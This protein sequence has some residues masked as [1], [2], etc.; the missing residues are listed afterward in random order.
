MTV[1][2]RWFAPLTVGMTNEYD[3]RGRLESILTPGA[4]GRS[5]RAPLRRRQAFALG[6]G[7][8]TVLLLLSLVN[9]GGTAYDRTWGPNS[10]FRTTRAFSASGAADSGEFF[11]ASG[12]MALRRGRDTTV[13]YSDNLL[14]WTPVLT[15]RTVPFGSVPG[16][17][18]S[19]QTFGGRRCTRYAFP[20]VS[21][22]R[23]RS[24]H[25]RYDRRTGPFVRP[26]EPAR[27]AADVGGV[28][29]DS[30]R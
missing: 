25:V 29:I 22:R 12:G 10:T 8:A 21:P 28:V 3:L 24:L 30:A 5:A 9:P 13:E 14:C 6:A 2:R 11:E 1:F 23:V 18:E 17:V 15:A 26:R 20:G 27:V 4:A 7:V 19:V 16:R